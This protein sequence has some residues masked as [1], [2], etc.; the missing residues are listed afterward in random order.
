MPFVDS[1]DIGLLIS[2]SWEVGNGKSISDTITCDSV[3]DDRDGL[4]NVSLD[5]CVLLIQG[6][7][8]TP[9]PPEIKVTVNKDVQIT[10]LCIVTEILLVH[11]SS[12]YRLP[13][14]YLTTIARKRMDKI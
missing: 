14:S 7:F 10:Q 3:V 9:C 1:Y 4:E 11:V 2:C 12:L 8:L 6:N 13:P 5:T